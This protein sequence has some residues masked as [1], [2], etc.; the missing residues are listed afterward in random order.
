MTVTET[1]TP[2][3]ELNNIRG[4]ANGVSDVSVFDSSYDSGDTGF[5]GRAQPGGSGGTSTAC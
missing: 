4:G 3:V 2:L 5:V 1:R